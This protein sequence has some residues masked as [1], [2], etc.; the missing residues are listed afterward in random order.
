MTRD[1]S[2]DP[3]GYQT[4][5]PFTALVNRPEVADSLAGR[6]P[7]R[8]S[9]PWLGGSQSLLRIEIVRYDDVIDTPSAR[10]NKY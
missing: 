1:Q 7:L 5:Y 2:L 4:K 9:R 10:K 6:P 8:R 3:S